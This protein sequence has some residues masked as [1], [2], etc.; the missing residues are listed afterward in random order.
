MT[1][2]PD[3]DETERLARELLAVSS[4]ADPDPETLAAVRRQLDAVR[5]VLRSDAANAPSAAALRRAEA[6][7]RPSPAPMGRPITERLRAVLTFDSRTVRPGFGFRGGATATMLR[8]EV[9]DLLIDLEVR[10]STATD[11]DLVDV[12]GQ[13]DGA[14]SGPIWVELRTSGGE[15]V[16]AGAQ[17]ELGAFKLTVPPGAYNLVARV[18]GLEVSVF[19]IGV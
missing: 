4:N 18:G 12:T 16:A 15:V 11:L 1:R 7:F 19:G 2:N 10:P 14:P 5:D 17:D 6:I 9:G 8:Y 3:D 13:I